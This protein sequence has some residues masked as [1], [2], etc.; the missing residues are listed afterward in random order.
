MLRNLAAYVLPFFL[1]LTACGSRKP[2]PFVVLFCLD[3]ATPEAFDQLRSE[4]KLPNID[5]LIRSGS[6]GPLES[7]GAKR[8][9]RPQPR[10]GYWSPIIWASVATGMIPEKHGIL[11]FLLPM[12]GTSFAWV[13]NDAGPPRA[14]L[15]LPE[16]NGRPPYTLRIRLR[17][18]P[19]NGPQDVQVHLNGAPVAAATVPVKWKDFTMDLP[20]ELL[21][22]AQNRVE[23]VFSKQS[24]PSDRGKSKDDRSLAG[25]FASLAVEDSRGEIVAS[26]DPVYQRFSLGKGFHLPEAELVEAQSAHFKTRPVWSLLGNLGHRIGVVGYWSTWPAYEVNGFLVS[27]RMGM[28]GRRQGTREHLTWPATLAD[29]LGPLSPTEEE[30]IEVVTD[31]YPPSC[32]PA[33]PKS[34]SVFEQV[35]WQDEFYFRIARKLLPTL[36]AGFFTVYFESIDVGSH[37]FLPYRHGAELPPDC[38][39]SVRDVADKTYARIDGWIGELIKGLPAHATVMVISDHG[40]V[41]ADNAGY[42]APYGVLVASGPSV[43]HAEL[44]GATVLDIA[45]TI[46]QLFGAPI[47]YEMDGKVLAQAFETEW[48]A[49]HT[50]RY[51]DM[52]T[53]IAERKESPL[54]EDTDEVIERLKSIGYIN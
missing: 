54:T 52:E 49:A 46:L 15:I 40:M 50:P 53:G 5:R 31:L 34:L 20:E 51:L 13:G 17:S 35:L 22:P 4:G 30:M 3:G 10:R 43:R 23:L 27:S 2:E 18:F 38:P 7:L 45:P 44:R 11:D 6:W 39:D 9:L 41:T 48:F 12:P 37:T 25:A 33:K 16:V 14:D 19:A 24:K 26:F 29:E 42:H 28:R 32:A 21:R 1:L 8:V 36:D 47:P